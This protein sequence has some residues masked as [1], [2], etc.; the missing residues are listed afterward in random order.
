MAI[1]PSDSDVVWVG[2]GEANDRNSSGWGDGV[3]RS[4]D[5]GGN[6]DE[7]WLE[8][9]PRDCAHRGASRQNRKSLTW[10][11]WE[12]SG[13]TAASAVS[14]KQPTPAKPGSF[15]A[16]GPPPNDARTGCGDVVLDPSNPEIVYAALYARQRTPWSFHLW[17]R[18]PP[19][20]RMLAEFSKARMAARPGKNARRPARPTGRIG[21]AV[22]ASNPKSSWPIV[23]SDEGGAS[24]IS[25]IHSRSGGVFRSEDGGEKWTR[26]SDINPR[27]FYFSQIRIDPANDQR[28]YVLGY[29][30][31][32]FG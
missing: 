5:G 20:V 30:A 7:C 32:R 28:V 27:P 23:Q 25:D 1:A 4:T 18:P 31:A 19:V 21:L 3:Y 2:T 6:L 10:R 13:R 16:G 15:L 8:G 26:M 11:R 14:T 17:S 9:K 24:D 22:S 12:I 29:G